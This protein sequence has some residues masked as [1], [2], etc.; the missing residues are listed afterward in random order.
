ML[1][2][3]P[4]SPAIRRW[5][6]AC[7][8]ALAGAFLAAAASAQNKPLQGQTVVLYTFG[9]TQLEVTR[10]LVIKPF[11]AETGAKVVVDDSCCTRMQATL[12]AGQFLGDVVVGLDRGGMLARADR[13]FFIA[14]PRLEK[15]ARDRGVPDPYP[16][17]NMV[18]LHSY[19]YVIAAKDRNIPLPKNWAEFF[20]TKK[21]PGTRGLIRVGPQVQLEAALLADGVPPDK[22]YPLDVERA[23]RKLDALR[24][25]TKLVINNSGADMIN[26]LGTGETTYGITYSNRA[27][28][29]QKDGIRINFGYDDGF[30]VGNG[31]AILK[32]AKNVNGA[33]AFLEY[34]LRPD[35]LARFA[36]RTGMGPSYR[37][38]ADMVDEK[39]RAMVPSA[40]ANAAKQHVMNDK[41]W[42]ANQIEQTKRW[43]N[44]LAQ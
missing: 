25:S 29:A 13:G 32:G 41:F 7:M 28:M 15:M 27:F 19:A 17:P 2:F 38:S 11:E 8:V 3:R 23:Y 12:E 16:S 22:L 26:N 1:N 43:I 20:D 44:W 33:V 18:V 31:G 5:T 37:A 35:V 24:A 30:L 9:G 14:D 36:E 39:A 10:E 34:H 4:A 21:F 6:A 40:P 42:Q